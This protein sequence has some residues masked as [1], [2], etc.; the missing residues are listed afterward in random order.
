VSA[1]QMPQ[2]GVVGIGGDGLLKSREGLRGH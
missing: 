2:V 1:E